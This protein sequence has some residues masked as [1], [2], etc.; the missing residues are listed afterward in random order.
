MP[1]LRH[2]HGPGPGWPAAHCTAESGDWHWGVERAALFQREVG[3]R[4][5]HSRVLRLG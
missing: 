2:R 4:D 3:A 5:A 1:V